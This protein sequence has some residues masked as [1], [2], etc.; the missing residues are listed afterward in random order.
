MDG[1]KSPSNS[2]PARK[3]GFSEASIKIQPLPRLPVKFNPA[4][5]PAI[6]RSWRASQ[7][8]KRKHLIH[9]QYFPELFR[10]DLQ[11]TWIGG[12]QPLQ[13]LNLPP[14]RRILTK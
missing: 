13:I 8:G 4:A 3:D 7:P 2:H 10:L 12:S 6:P 1:E 11:F 9:P 14:Y 5:A